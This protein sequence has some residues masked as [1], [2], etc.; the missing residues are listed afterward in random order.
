[1]DFGYATDPSTVIKC[2]IHDEE[3]ELHIFEEAHGYHIEIEDLPV[4]IRTVSGHEDN[5]IVADSSRPETISYLSRQGF[6]ML[7]SQKG[8]GSIMEGIE[9]IKN[10]KVVV[11]IKCK[12]TLYELAHYS[13][14]VDARTGLIKPRAPKDKDNH[15]I[16]SL[17][18]ALSY[19]FNRTVPQFIC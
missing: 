13:Y 9:F 15:L 12:N 6:Y 18:Y 4:L 17:R 19:N 3:R 5:H 2:C 11:D 16:D 10:F 1:M 8:P 7:P 14:E